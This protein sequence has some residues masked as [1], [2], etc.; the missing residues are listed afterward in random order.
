[1]LF[2]AHT[3]QLF[4]STQSY[5][6]W[7]IKILPIATWSEALGSLGMTVAQG[8]TP[9]TAALGRQRQPDGLQSETL[10]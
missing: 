5:W 2:F 6:D 10:S 8:Y 4:I 1:M 7:N 9:L 3:D